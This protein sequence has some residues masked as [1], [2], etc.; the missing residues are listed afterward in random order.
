MCGFMIDKEDCNLRGNP[1]ISQSYIDQIR[2]D[3]LSRMLANDVKNIII[4]LEEGEEKMLFIDDEETQI[5][6]E[7]GQMIYQ[8]IMQELLRDLSQMMI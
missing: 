5:L 4:Q 8:S 6:V 1:N 7:V 2:D 3:R